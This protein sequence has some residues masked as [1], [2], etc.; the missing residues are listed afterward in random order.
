MS[1][2]IEIK[3][4][5]RQDRYSRHLNAVQQTTLTLCEIL[6]ALQVFVVSETK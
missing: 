6:N 3:I 2:N 5:Q 4:L 1:K